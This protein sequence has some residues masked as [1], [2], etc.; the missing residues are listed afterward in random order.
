[1][2]KLLLL[3]SALAFTSFGTW[4]QEQAPAPEQQTQVVASA[5]DAKDASATQGENATTTEQPK[6]EAPQTTEQ[7]DEAAEKSSDPDVL[8]WEEMVAFCV[9]VVAVIGLGIWKASD[10]KDSEKSEDE[11]AEKG[12]ADYFLAGRGLTWWLVGFSLLAANISTEQFVGMSG[13]AADWLGLA[14]AGYEWL[15]AIVLVIVAF[16]FLPMLLKRG[17][18]TIPQFLEERYNGVSRVTMALVNLLIL[19]GVPTATVI[20]AGANVI[21]V[22]FS[23]DLVTSCLIIAGA[24]TIYVYIGGLKACA[25]TDLIWGAALIVGGGVVAY[26][27]I[28]KLGSMDASALQ[29]AA[30]TAT[31]TTQAT[32]QSMAD[33]ATGNQFMDGL[34]RMSELNSGAV[35]NSVNGIGGKLH[36][37]RE[38][39][40]PVMPWTVYLLG[41]WIPNF[42]YWGLNQYIM[43]R[44]LASKSLEEGQLGIVFAAF[45]KLLIPFVVIIPGVLAFNLF[46]GD[47]AD[48]ADEE[49][50]KIVQKA[51]ETAAKDG[52][53]VIYD[54]KFNLLMRKNQQK[55]ALAYLMANLQTTETANMG[56]N[57]LLDTYAEDEAQ[58][59]KAMEQALYSTFVLND[60]I[61]NVDSTLLATNGPQLNQYA[62]ELGVKDTETVATLLGKFEAPQV[63]QEKVLSVA[64]KN[65]MNQY[66]SQHTVREVM[67][68][69]ADKLVTYNADSK[70]DRA[71][72]AELSQMIISIENLATKGARNDKN[73]YE[74]TTGMTAYHYD[75]AFAILLKN[76]L[77]NT[78][79]AWFVLAALFGAVVSSLASM[80]NS[81]ST[82]FTMDLYGK[83]REVL[84][85]PAS[86]AELL[87]VGKIGVLGCAVIATVIAPFLNNPAFGGIFTF[88]QEFQGFLS[89]GVLAVFLFGF[90]VPKCP[91]IFG[92]L[93]ILLG[94]VFY[95]SFKWITILGTTDMSFLNR[96]ALSFIAVSVVGII[97][98]LINHLKGG[99]A[100]V[101]TDKGLIEM[102][103]ST[104]AKV[105]GWAVI[106]LTIAL[107]IIFW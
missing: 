22:Y 43:Q 106:V 14:I 68:Q 40:D 3:L 59:R 98:T 9:V 65:S 101:L 30:E 56:M 85:R 6:A 7:K 70:E 82:L 83:T 78:G 53:S 50:A 90:F 23:M 21:S 45:L 24:A 38:A 66:L 1:M 18:F 32:A 28:M 104:R 19:V 79:W 75:S 62:T 10:G 58:A 80:L 4:A 107:Y 92:W 100:V 15:A 46:R 51:E 52:K 72:V 35:E 25:W 91:R 16:T 33:A 64:L 87:S 41:L 34:S 89:P 54:V 55:Q 67:Q 77:P 97:L 69:L 93:G 17:V 36:M 95:A 29:V 105:F 44:T 49:N 81:A 73:A 5:D 20:Y 48:K 94:A 12:A 47:L 76:L 42:F 84:G 103:T 2:K 86:P 39:N 99:E 102:K 71:K 57:K 27:A 61:K 8:P 26:F 31:T 88:I 63:E 60:T 96:M 11:K 74:V 37:M 13:Q